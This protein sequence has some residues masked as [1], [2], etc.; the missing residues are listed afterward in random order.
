M[1]FQPASYVRVRLTAIGTTT[2]LCAGLVIVAPTSASAGDG[3]NFVSEDVVSEALAGVDQSL[4]HTPVDGAGMGEVVL[5]GGTVDVPVELT[6]GVEISA[7]GEAS[8]TVELPGAA[9]AGSATELA[10]GVVTFPAQD[11]SNS[12]VVSEAGTQMITTIAGK[13]APTQFSYEVS[14]QPGQSLQLLGA[15]A[16]VVNPDGT[17]AVA[18]GRPWAVDAKGSPIPTNYE[19]DGSSLVQVVDHTSDSVAYPVVADPIWLAPWVVRCLI[20]IGLNGPQISRIASAGSLG[21]I[22]AAFGYGALR[23][24]LGR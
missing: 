1:H 23:C 15:G 3:T 21:A 10:D 4:L 17:L 9:N 16:A 6:D 14:L 13:V 18:V 11:F 2:A 19:V 22:F 8:L 12:I 20:G 7:A 5:E 24:V